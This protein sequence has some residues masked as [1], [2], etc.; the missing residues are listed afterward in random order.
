MQTKTVY[1]LMILSLFVLMVLLAVAAFAPQWV[2]EPIS[3]R[4]H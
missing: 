3:S 1:V 2:F 4:M